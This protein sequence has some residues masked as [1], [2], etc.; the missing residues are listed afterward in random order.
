MLYTHYSLSHVYKYSNPCKD[1]NFNTKVII[2]YKFITT[3]IY[4]HIFWYV[5]HFF[6][7]FI[8]LFLER[9]EGREKEREGNIKVWLPPACTPPTGDL[10][11][12]P[13]MCPDWESNQ[14]PFGLQAGTQSTEPHQ[15]WLLFFICA[16]FYDIFSIYDWIDFADWRCKSSL[17]THLLLLRSTWKKQSI[18]GGTIT[19]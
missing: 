4:I 11:C 9:E 6:K 7:D 14:R 1:W 8:Y 18:Q 19:N 10:A 15:P 3:Y 17:K 16:K 12:N 13:G 5:C 2:S